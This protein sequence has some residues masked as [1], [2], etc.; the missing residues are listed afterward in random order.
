VELLERLAALTPR[1]RI[2]HR[3]EQLMVV[4]LTA[5]SWT[6]LKQ[7]RFADAEPTL[8]E[9]SDSVVRTSPE[10]WER[11]FAIYLTFGEKT[12][13]DLWL[14]PLRTALGDLCTASRFQG[15]SRS[16]ISSRRPAQTLRTGPG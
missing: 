3:P 6:R 5:V 11:D 7:G 2:N 8:R 14:L 1:P 4:T 16:G 13:Q 15:T 12:G 9:L 10:L